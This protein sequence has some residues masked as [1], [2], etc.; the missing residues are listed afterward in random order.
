MCLI[1]FSVTSRLKQVIHSAVARCG[2][3]TS[4][5]FIVGWPCILRLPL[6]STGT[7]TRKRRRWWNSS[8]ALC[9]SYSSICNRL[10]PLYKE[11]NK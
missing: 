3:L 9:R 7:T 11:S 2:D 8:T 4:N 1:S 5:Q 10:S 6:W